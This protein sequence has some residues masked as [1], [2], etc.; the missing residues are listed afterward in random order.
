MHLKLFFFATLIAGTC[1]CQA[2]H[3]DILRPIHHLFDGMR[4]SDGALIS[5]AFAPEATMET[6]L[7]KDGET[8]V[9]TNSATDFIRAASQP[10]E[11]VWNEVIWSY[12]VRKDGPLATVWTEYTFY[13]GNKRLHCGVNAFQLMHDG[14]EWKITRV[15]DTPSPG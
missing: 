11:E 1:I 13:L 9:A 7:T 15:T 6:Y 4:A 8:T 10:H 5:S 2:Q 12:D 3:S 14:V